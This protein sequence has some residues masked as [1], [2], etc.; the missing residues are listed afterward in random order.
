MI[1]HELGPDGFS[2]P[3]ACMHSYMDTIIHNHVKVVAVE[4]DD[5]MDEDERE[6]KRLR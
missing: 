1:E 4:E 6:A 3:D 5:G 2:M